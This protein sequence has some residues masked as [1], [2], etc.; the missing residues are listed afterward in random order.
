MTYKSHFWDFPGR[1]CS[2]S[3]F[4]V[5]DC[6]SRPAAV[7]AKLNRLTFHR[8]HETSKA[9]AEHVTSAHSNVRELWRCLCYSVLNMVRCGV[10]GHPREWEWLGCH[11]IMGK[12]RRYRLLDLER[13]F[14]R[15]RTEDSAEAKRHLEAALTEAIANGQVKRE[16]LWTE[17]LAVGSSGFLEKIKPLILS[18][19]ETEVVEMAEDLKALQEAPASYGRKT[20]SKSGANDQN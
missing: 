10:A 1:I 15:L 18:R 9:V 4:P 16:P 5:L 3:S 19:L 14:W 12:R 20:G 8:G 13:L 6:A 7:R 11:E 17:S 2:L